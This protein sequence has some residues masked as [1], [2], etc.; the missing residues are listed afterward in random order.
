M[1]KK[2]L[3]LLPFI[4]VIGYIGLSSYSSGPAFVGGF[5]YTTSLGCATSGCH[6]SSTSTSDTVYVDSAGT[7]VTHYVAGG[8]YTIT[9]KGVNLTGAFLLP[10]FGFQLEV[11]NTAGV[12][13]STAN[14]GTLATTGLPTSTHNVVSSAGINIFEHSVAIPA[15]SGGGFSGS[16][17]T[18]SISWI[19]PASGF[20]SVYVKGVLNAVNGDGTTSGDQV[21]FANTVALTEIIAPISGTLSVCVGAATTLTD[22]TASGSWS[23]L[24]PSIAT[25]NASGVVTGLSPGT[26]VIRYTTPTLGFA[27]VTVTVNAAPNAGTISGPGSVCSGASISL[28]DAGSVGAGVWSTTTP[29]NTTVDA[30]GNVT[31]LAAGTGTIKYT[32]TN[33]CGSASTTYNVTVN[34]LPSVGIITGPGNVCVGSSISLTDTAGGTWGVDLPARATVNASGVVTGLSGG[35]VII[36]YSLSNGCG[37]TFATHSVNVN[38]LPVAGTISGPTGVCRGAAITLTDAGAS[39]A[40]TWSSTSTSIATVS[41]STGVVH[42]VAVGSDTIRFIVFNSCGSD[43]ARYPITVNPLPNAG[44]ITGPGAVCVG[45]S[46]SLADV[47][48]VGNGGWSSVSP[49]IATVDASGMVTGLSAGTAAIV[50]ADTTVCGTTTTLH[51]VVVQNPLTAGP[52]SGPSSVCAGSNI[53]LSGVSSGGV[54]VSSTPGVATVNAATGLVH[55]VSS[56]TTTITYIVSNS[57]GNDTAYYPVTVNP[58]PVAGTLSGAGTVCVGATTTLTPSVGLGVWSSTAPLTATV[59]S[60]GV[61]GLLAG[62]ATISYTVSNG[63]GNAAATKVMTVNA[64]ANA[65]S[66]TGATSVCVGAVV[67]LGETASGGSWACNPTANATIT[68]GSGALSG[69]SAGTVNITYTVSNSCNTATANRTVTINPLPVPGTISGTSTFCQGTSVTLSETSGGGTWS[70]GSPALATVNAVSGMV[71]GL[72]GGAAVISYA[73]TNGCGTLY[74]TYTVNITPLTSAGT[75]TGSALPCI[76]I[77]NTLSDAVSGGTWSC[78]PASVATIDPFGVV[79]GVA[80][81]T[82][83]VTYTVIGTCNTATAFYTVSVN[84]SASV[85]PITG[86]STVCQGSSISLADAS[87]GGSWSSSNTAIASVDG[88]GVVTGTGSGSVIINY[89]LVTGCGIATASQAVTVNPL[90]YAGVISGIAV[91]CQ[92]SSVS[93]GET[94]T[95]GTWSTSPATVATVNASGVV[96]GLSA[97]IVVVAYTVSNSCGMVLAA[98]TM[99]VNPLPTTGTV[100]GPTSQCQGSA[101]TLTSSL[102]GGTWHASNSAGTVNSFGVVTGTGFGIDTIYYNFTNACGTAGGSLIDTIYPTSVAGGIVGDDTVCQGDTVHLSVAVF[103]GTWSSTNLHAF[104]TPTGDMIGVIPGI[105]TIVYSMTNMCGTSSASLRVVVRSFAACAAGVSNIPVVS[106]DIAVYPNPASGIFTVEIPET[107]EEATITIFDLLGKV[108][109]TRTVDNNAGSK[110]TFNMSSL[111]PGSYLVKVQSGNKN[112]RQK[113][114]IR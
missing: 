91:F 29:T 67:T 31:G 4:L 79:Y 84:T 13:A 51:N 46:I 70:S 48:F 2:L 42:G 21:K 65:G 12:T 72:S 108:M 6:T 23:S 94:V 66:I 83:T 38:S 105:D 112:Y 78:N 26:A 54:W 93:L 97:G 88:S 5:D 1:K 17:Y 81:G 99:T 113:I 64:L 27:S 109:E 92:G 111:A 96:T 22:P 57:C 3:L 76:G 73:A 62:T 90:P 56:G 32:A 59:N 102:T 45:S 18:E 19:A 55:G 39:G 20:G 110:T 101:I 63:C 103:G 58:L 107:N 104:V 24:S 37:N 82:A 16:V 33:S 74:A 41:I 71:T 98:H 25:I 60:G 8:H 44:T 95:G 49:T 9:I 100:T 7:R 75:I 28:T 47:T 35:A 36:S 52:L 10:K 69:V 50:F 11:V 40:G 89:N 61:T 15:T 30:A 86:A 14:A 106:D 87:G 80:S 85:S 68:A 43:T 53:S 34:P 77:A 114:V